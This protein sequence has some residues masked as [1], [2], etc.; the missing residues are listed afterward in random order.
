MLVSGSHRGSGGIHWCVS[1][2]DAQDAPSVMPSHLSVG[3]TEFAGLTRT[4][5]GTRVDLSERLTGPPI[6]LLGTMSKDIRGFAVGLRGGDFHVAV[7]IQVANGEPGRR[8]A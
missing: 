6:E 7:A 8:T 1:L 2:P 4:R 3:V 5:K